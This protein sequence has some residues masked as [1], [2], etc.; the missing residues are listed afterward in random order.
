[1]KNAGEQILSKSFS[2]LDSQH[3]CD[4]MEFAP[5]AVSGAKFMFRNHS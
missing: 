2:K 3:F 4:Q 5:Q 1:V